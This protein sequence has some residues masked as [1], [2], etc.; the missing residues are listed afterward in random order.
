MPIAT[1]AANRPYL[2]GQQSGGE[3][4]EN[5]APAQYSNSGGDGGADAAS[6]P[7]DISHLDG[8]DTWG[9]SEA[10]ELDSSVWRDLYPGAE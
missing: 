8:I 10:A 5:T 6:C 4:G 3:D 9:M 2:G 1:P 7:L